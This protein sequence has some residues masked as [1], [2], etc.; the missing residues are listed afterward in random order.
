MEKNN[1]E[2]NYLI[3]FI[4][5]DLHKYDES[6]IFLEKVYDNISNDAFY[7]HTLA[8][9]YHHMGLNL[10]S[11]ILYEKAFTLPEIKD[12]DWAYFN[13]GVTLQ[14]LGKVV[15]AVE[16]YNKAIELNQNNVNAWLNVGMLHTKFGDPKQGILCYKYILYNCTNVSS[17]TVDMASINLGVAYELTKDYNNAIDSYMKQKQKYKMDYPYNSNKLITILTH[18]SRIKRSIADFT[19]YENDF[20]QLWHLVSNKLMATNNTEQLLLPFDSLL[21]PIDPTYQLLIASMHAK[22]FVQSE[23]LVINKKQQLNSNHR[24]PLRIG[25]ISYDFNDH[26]TAHLM[27]INFYICFTLII[28]LL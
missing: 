18:L 5:V 12:K 16:I 14:D 15:K 10:K 2:C 21:F 1:I 9:A 24:Y 23:E 20:D 25:Y 19:D 17:E 13:Y 27:V 11:E 8:L 28:Y 26:P 4:L 6:I 7:F 22:S 3:G